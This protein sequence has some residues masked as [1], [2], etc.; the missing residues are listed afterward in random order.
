[1]YKPV[2][3][4]HLRRFVVSCTRDPIVEIIEIPQTVVVFA[5]PVSI[6]RTNGNTHNA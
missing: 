1:M 2:A 3:S 6:A 4:S 5:I